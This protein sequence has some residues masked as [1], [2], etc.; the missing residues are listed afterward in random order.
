MSIEEQLARDIA[1]VTRGVV[2]TDSDLRDAR[3][4]IDD[5]LSSR[6]PEDPRRT[7]IAAAAAAVLLLVA[8]IAAYVTIGGDNET[9]PPTAPG[10]SA[11][12]SVDFDAEFLTGSAPTSDLV[13]GVWRLDNGGVLMRFTAGGRLSWDLGGRLF[14]SPRIQGTYAIA[15]DTITVSVDGGPAGCSGQ[16]VAMRASV[17][18]QGSLHLVFT[19]PRGGACGTYPDERWVMEQVLPASPSM[20]SFKVSGA[21]ADWTP[22]RNRNLLPGTWSA[23]GGGHL[24]ELARN[25]RYNVAAGSGEPVDAGEWSLDGSRLTLTSTADSTGC[26]AGDRLVLGA[27]QTS[28]F[29]TAGIRSTVREN[30]CGAAWAETD[31]FL[32]P[33]DGE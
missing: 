32:I 23:V 10:P 19:E 16:Q 30:T 33:H 15:G 14:E 5:R 3:T 27:V 1:E 17:P 7:A 26:R 6:Q 28:S 8:G 13:E 25:G 11:S 12:P 4:A 9:A 20:A 24:L 22:L 31:W 18:D 2:V 21:E 29:G